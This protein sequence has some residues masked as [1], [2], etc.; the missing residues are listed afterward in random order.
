MSDSLWLHGLQHSRLPGP[1][2]SP[3][4]CSN[5][6]PLSWWCHPTVSSSVVLSSF[7]LQ[8][9]PHQGLFQWVG[10]L[11]Q[12]SK[13]L[14][15]QLQRQCCNEYSGLISFKIESSPVPQFESISFSV[16]SLLYGP[17]IT[18]IHNY[19]KNHSFEYT[20]LCRKSDVCF[21]ICCLCFYSSFYSVQ[22]A[23]T[24]IF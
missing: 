1:S 12:V 13:V 7:C 18:S 10:P 6:C 23:R 17:T 3:R 8:S 21:L 16:L 11:N 22:R 4:V 20:D 14:E 2:P 19:W 9:F 15:I 24:L 5:F